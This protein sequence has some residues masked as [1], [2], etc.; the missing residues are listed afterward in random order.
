MTREE[1]IR[2]FQNIT[3]SDEGEI[4][5]GVKFGQDR[6]WSE[7]AIDG[8]VALGMLK[9]DEP[10]GLLDRVEGVIVEIP[11]NERYA[12]TIINALDVAGLKIVEK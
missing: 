7:R 1:A 2:T 4:S 12:A 6:R 10:K 11:K 8:F 9:L 3:Y 5:A